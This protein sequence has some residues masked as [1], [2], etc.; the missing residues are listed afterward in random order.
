MCSG[1]N[2][3]VFKHTVSLV[4]EV[5]GRS[6]DLSI[7]S[8]CSSI[9]MEV[10]LLIY[11]SSCLSVWIETRCAFIL[12]SELVFRC[13]RVSCVPLD[14]TEPFSPRS[15]HQRFFI[16]APGP[17]VPPPGLHHGEQL[18]QNSVLQAEHP[19][20]DA[21]RRFRHRRIPVAPEPCQRRTGP[22]EV[23]G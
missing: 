15:F 21:A 6:D 13:C 18:L 20:P 16:S 17:P 19:D 5:S 7:W 9:R 23:P 4:L 14:V 11:L 8:V 3:C 22:Q 2:V 12:K 1:V 10:G